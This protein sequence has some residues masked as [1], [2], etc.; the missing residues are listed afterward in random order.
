MTISFRGEDLEGKVA[1][2]RVIVSRKNNDDYHWTL[3]EMKDGVW[4]DLAGL[5]YLRVAGL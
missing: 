3:Q 1:D 4:K 2:L 5:E